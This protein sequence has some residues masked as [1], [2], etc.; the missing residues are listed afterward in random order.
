M[1]ALKPYLIRAFYEWIVA[2]ELTPH[3]LVDA[4]YP[5]TEV[6]VN[7]VDNGQIAL[8]IRPAAVDRLELG[9]EAITFNTRF[10][11]RKTS[12]NAPIDSILAIYAKENGKGMLFEPETPQAPQTT[13]KPEL[14]IVK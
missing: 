6:P 1:T 9:N 2:N 11:G 4:T 13:K 14:R 10:G 7:M 8:N 12:I 5:G 3:L